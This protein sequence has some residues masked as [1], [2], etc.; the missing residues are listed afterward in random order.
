MKYASDSEVFLG[1]VEDLSEWYEK[2]RL[3]IA[4]ARFA[5]GIP[6]KIIEAASKGIPVVATALARNQLGWTEEELISVN[7][8]E[9]FADACVRVYSEAPLW[10]QLRIG[11]LATERHFHVILW[12]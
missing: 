9:G 6:L 11:A 5:A 4:P 3:F 12:R 7:T 8:A 1:F 10:H 2:C